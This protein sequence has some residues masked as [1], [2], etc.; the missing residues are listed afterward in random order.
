MVLDGAFTALFLL[1]SG[2]SAVTVLPPINVSVSCENFMVTVSWEYPEQQPQTIFRVNILSPAGDLERETED[3]QFD[4]SDI[5]WASQDHYMGYYHVSVTAI[6]GGNQSEA[7]AAG[8]FSFNDLKSSD[9]KCEL[10]FP[11]ANLIETDLG[12][13]LKFK[14][15]LL[16][17]E[18][19]KRTLEF[20]DATFRVSVISNDGEILKFCD[21][22]NIDSDDCNSCT[23]RDEICKHDI[24]FAKGTKKCVRLKGTLFDKR[25]FGQVLFRE[26]DSICASKP[27]EAPVVLLVTL[28]S[29]TALV[30]SLLTV[31][32]CKAKAWTMETHE[33]LPESLLQKHRRRGSNLVN[34]HDP[35]F[36]PVN[37]AES[38]SCKTHSVSSEEE[39][40][41]DPTD[42]CDGGSDSGSLSQ[43]PACF[44]GDAKDLDGNGTD[45][46]SAD[47]S[48]KTECVSLC[49]EEEEKKEEEK[50]KPLPSYYDSPHTHLVDIPDKDMVT[51][52][53]EK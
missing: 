47:D 31:F 52:H 26:T 49:L 40:E 23:W 11:P 24:P 15:P 17:N 6:Q 41:H 35:D 9:M 43:P 13:I 28:L 30:I 5:I 39:E 10:V 25:Y 16:A 1:V 3:H 36:S 8:S 48:V 50:P 29:I 37:L 44:Y 12:A 27:Y 38:K 45:D 7:R 51:A 34:E 14:N 32:I 42:H 33:P 18:K 2:A 46:E 4:L 21:K 53:G 20:D 19:L 22:Q